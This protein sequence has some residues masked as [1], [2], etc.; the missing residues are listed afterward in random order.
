VALVQIPPA[1]ATPLQVSSG[2]MDA[3]AAEI[4]QRGDS[5]LTRRAYAAAL[6]GYRAWLERER[7]SWA[8][9][10]RLDLARYRS[11]LVDRYSPSH[12]NKG[13]IVVRGLYRL[14][15]TDDLLPRNLAAGLR[16]AKGRDERLGDALT[17]EEARAVL[18]AIQL[19][20]DRPSRRLI[21]LR[22]SALVLLGFKT[23]PRRS[24]LAA[25]RLRDLGE[26]QGHR[27]L[28]IPDG[29]GAVARTVK[30]APEVGRAIDTWVEAAELL[31]DDPLFVAVG[32]GGRLDPVPRPLDPASVYRIVARRLEAA[33][34]RRL[35]PHRALRAT[36]ATLALS[37]GAPLH[38]VQAAL[39]HADPR[40]TQRY[41]LD[42]M[43]L[44]DNA[45]DYVRL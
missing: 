35:G 28:D 40:V 11:E 39:G 8:E 33:G 17:R 25:A 26:R 1:S 6:A 41:T 24:E 2:A 31:L 13:L 20:F 15:W 42:R 32:K 18:D 21:A 30:V 27:V 3:L 37:G 44:D 34:V 14:A 43:E 22:D 29:K 16:G 45:T 36:A 7:L 4:V 23:G 38:K 10:T 19:D 5:A 9:V 12:A